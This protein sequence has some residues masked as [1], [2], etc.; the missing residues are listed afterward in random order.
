MQLPPGSLGLPDKPFLCIGRAFQTLPWLIPIQAPRCC[1]SSDALFLPASW[2]RTQGAREVRS[3][4]RGRLP[5]AQSTGRSA[6]SAAAVPGPHPT[7]SS[8]GK[9]DGSST[10]WDSKWT[11]DLIKGLMRNRIMPPGAFS[12]IVDE[13][14]A[15]RLN[16]IM[17][18]LMDF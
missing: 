17:K 16:E 7:T 5:T 8:S 18:P 10:S 12:Y 3:R 15:W 11:S 9:A 13:S 2:H 1:F 6:G 4:L 14:A